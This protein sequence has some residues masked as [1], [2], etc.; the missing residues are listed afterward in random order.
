M[1]ELPSAA[2]PPAPPRPNQP[3]QEGCTREDSGKAGPFS[4]ERLE[5]DLTFVD[6]SCVQTKHTAGRGTLPD[7][8]PTASGEQAV[9]GFERL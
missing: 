7:S 8:A 3:G 6:V 2:K 5:M 9:K 4:V 1:A